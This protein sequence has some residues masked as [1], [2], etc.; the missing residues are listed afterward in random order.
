MS[1]SPKI[2]VTGANG[3]IG[4]ALISKLLEEGKTVRAFSH[5]DSDKQ[6]KNNNL[7]CFYGDILDV[8][9]IDDICKGIDTI[10]HCEEMISFNMSE[11]DKMYNINVIGTENIVNAALTNEVKRIIDI[12]MIFPN[13]W[14]V[15]HEIQLSSITTENLENRTNDYRKLGIDVFWW[16]GKSADKKANREWAIEKY[17]QSLSINYELLDS[18]YK[19][20]QKGKNI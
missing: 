9:I 7:E 11:E 16:F 17:G 1:L 2:L 18:K 15:A 3:M 6:A 10:F 8:G 12:A 4:S 5:I 20:L 14:I 19:D 13:G